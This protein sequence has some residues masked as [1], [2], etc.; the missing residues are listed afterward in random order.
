MQS[1]LEVQ[2]SLVL[3]KYRDVKDSAELIYLLNKEFNIQY[4]QDDL[5]SLHV[6]LTELEIADRTIEAYGNF[7][8]CEYS[9]I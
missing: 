2:V 5:L 3:S 7:T 9:I 4:S 1:N 8:E 6:D